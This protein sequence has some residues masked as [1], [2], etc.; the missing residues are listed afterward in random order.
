MNRHLR[1]DSTFRRLY[2]S[3]N[4]SILRKK[5]RKYTNEQ[6]GVLGVYDTLTPLYAT[7]HEDDRTFSFMWTEFQ[8][9]FQVFYDA[10][11]RNQEK[12]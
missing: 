9:K 12:F 8:E 2:L 6:D 4:E 11:I 7:F 5:E 10:Y 3:G 1:D